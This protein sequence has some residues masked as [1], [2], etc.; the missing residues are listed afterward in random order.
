MVE[1]KESIAGAI[2]GSLTKIF[3]EKLRSEG[4]I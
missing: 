1:L 4:F 3:Y 2:T